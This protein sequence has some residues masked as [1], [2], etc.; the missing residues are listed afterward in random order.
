MKKKTKS[1]YI[2]SLLCW[3]L[4]QSHWAL[5][6]AQDVPYFNLIKSWK[7]SRVY[8]IWYPL[9]PRSQPSSDNYSSPWTNNIASSEIIFTLMRWITM[10]W[11]GDIYKNNW[12][13]DLFFSQISILTVVLSTPPPNGI[14]SRWCVFVSEQ[15]WTPSCSQPYIPG[16]HTHTIQMQ[17]WFYIIHPAVQEKDYLI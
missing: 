9:A 14:Q 5:W 7:L 4:F 10:F 13:L 6:I 2:P 3:S 17:S 11:F 8:F 16:D 15:Y 1:S 12:S